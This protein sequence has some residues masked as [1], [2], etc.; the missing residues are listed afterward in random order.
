M[1]LTGRFAYLGA[2]LLGILFSLGWAPCAISLILPVIILLLTA[3]V[4]LL[5]GGAM[6]FI[7]GIGHGLPA[8]PLCMLT[9]EIRGGLGQS[10]AKA[11]KWLTWCFGIVV[12]IIGLLMVLRP[13]GILLW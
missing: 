12:V 5:V 9:S 13:F 1:A 3:K 2:F 8:I 6:L 11:G 10:Y 4:P 7:F